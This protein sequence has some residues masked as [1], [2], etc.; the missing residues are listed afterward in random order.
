MIQYL[1]VLIILVLPFLSTFINYKIYVNATRTTSISNTLHVNENKILFK[2]IA[3]QSIF[4]FISQVPA[5]SYILYYS[6]T[7]N[8]VIVAEITLSSFYC[9][10]NGFCIFLS[11]VIIK[12][13]RN[14]MI[15]DFRGTKI[16]VPI[17]NTVRTNRIKSIS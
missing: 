11:L 3:I 14:M 16:A 17:P 15:N 2:G 9:I 1:D 10:G 13:F 8:Q 4:P 12:E 5:I 7:R 6:A